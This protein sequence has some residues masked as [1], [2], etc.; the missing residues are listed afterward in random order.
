MPG[1]GAFTVTFKNKMAKEREDRRV[2]AYP[3]ML[4][5]S[6]THRSE[7]RLEGCRERE[8]RE[9]DFTNI[10]NSLAIFKSKVTILKFFC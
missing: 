2:S 5:R 6:Q 4:T 10:C 1:R 7:I 9:F 3:E 8:R